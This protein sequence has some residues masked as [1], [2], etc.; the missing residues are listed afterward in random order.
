MYKIFFILLINLLF[1]SPSNAA[2][3]SYICEWG[4][5]ISE[6]NK[7]SKNVYEIIDD[8]VYEDSKELDIYFYKLSRKNIE[9]KYS[10]Y[11]N[12]NTKF[13]YH[14]KLNIHTGIAFETFSTDAGDFNE[15]YGAVCEFI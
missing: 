15:A 1:F 3:V 5:E 14:F 7:K 2:T 10:K 13:N 11:N 4:A 8:K 12:I 9:Y 6:D